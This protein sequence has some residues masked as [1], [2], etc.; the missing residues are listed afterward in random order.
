MIYPSWLT[1]KCTMCGVGLL[2]IVSHLLALVRGKAMQTWLRAFPRN[3]EAGVLLTIAASAWFFRLVQV[4]DLGEFSPWRDT[5]L[6]LTP[7]AGILSILYMRDFLAVRALGT[8]ALLAA[9]PLLESAF[10]RD[11]STR[12]LL[13]TLTYV[14]I[15]AGM[16]WVGMPYT[17]R[18]QI[19]WITASESRW[20][21]AVFAGIGYGVALL[22]GGLLVA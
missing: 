7:I 6:I 9:Q 5:V 14:W 10:L 4:M 19:T 20:R 21:T 8:L 17:L 15:I 1:L 2:L 18:D 12:L 3:R 16:F 22:V 11:E 13:V